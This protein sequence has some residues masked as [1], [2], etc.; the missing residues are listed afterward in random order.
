M[1]GTTDWLSEILPQKETRVRYASESETTSMPI[2]SPP[3]AVNNVDVDLIAV[4]LGLTL[5]LT[6]V[7]LREHVM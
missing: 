4:L 7:R 2:S 5:G 3:R 1:Q 6:M